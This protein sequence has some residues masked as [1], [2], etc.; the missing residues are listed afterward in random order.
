M[1]KSMARGGRFATP[2]DP[3][4]AALL[5]SLAVDWRLLGDDVQGSLAHVRMLADC[6]IIPAPAAEHIAVGLQEIGQRWADG[7]LPP[8]VEWEDVHMN[9][10]GYLHELIGDDAGFLHTARSRNDQVALDMHL[11]MRRQGK[12]IGSG[13]GRVLLSLAD[14]AART[15]DVVMPGYTHLQPAQPIRMAHHWLAYAAMLRRDLDRLHEWQRRVNQ[16]PL[17]AG[18]LAGTPYPTDPQQVADAL[19]FTALYA[20]SLDAVSDRDYLVE[21]LSWASLFMMH[22]SRLAEELV[23]WSSPQ[24]GFVALSEAYSTGS[25][26]MPQKRN[27]DAAELLRGKAGRVFGSLMALLTVMKGLPLAYNSDM[28]EDKPAV[29]DAVDTV[30]SALT[31]LPGL[32]DTLTV[33]PPVMQA[34]AAAHFIGATDL[35]DRLVLTGMPFRHAHHLVGQ[36]VRIALERGYASF[37]EIPRQLLIEMVPEISPE[38]LAQVDPRQLADARRQPFATARESIAGQLADLYQW[39]QTNDRHGSST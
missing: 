23:L 25:S 12:I 38:L 5:S 20:N 36:L 9:V 2:L 24:M 32:L 31:L 30:H 22:V 27:P 18:A 33:F 1:S 7:T 4:A 8:R 10:E 13:V 21:F 15:I 28:Q 14:L 39:L 19:G 35:A 37:A 11:Y 6:H 29:F 26:I 34:A 17:G 16:S 3:A